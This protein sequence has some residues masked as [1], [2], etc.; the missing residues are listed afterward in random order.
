VTPADHAMMFVGSY[1]INQIPQFSGCRIL[2]QKFRRAPTSQLLLCHPACYR[3]E[4]YWLQYSTPAA[5]IDRSNVH[6]NHTEAPKWHIRRVEADPCV[7]EGDG[8]Y[9]FSGLPPQ[10]ID[11][12]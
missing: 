8:R 2:Q 12:P 11:N 6:R 4:H 5:I 10:L 9:D 1:R 7:N 3:I